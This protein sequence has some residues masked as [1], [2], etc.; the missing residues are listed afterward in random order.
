[1]R[2]NLFFIYV[3]FIAL[4]T[5]FVFWFF[6]SNRGMMENPPSDSTTSSRTAQGLRQGVEDG[7][8]LIE[9]WRQVEIPEK[10]LSYE[11]PIAWFRGNLVGV[12]KVEWE[13]LDLRYQ[14]MS[15]NREWTRKL[16]VAIM[17]AQEKVTDPVRVRFLGD[18]GTRRT[19]VIQKQFLHKLLERGMPLSSRRHYT[20]RRIH[21]AIT[22]SQ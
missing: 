1:M 6:L 16:S 9:A 4:G 21:L 15:I 11:I 3:L 18:D 20:A 8:I 13:S 10:G 7:R 2:R 17:K 12:S 14:T 22:Q 5:T 19:K